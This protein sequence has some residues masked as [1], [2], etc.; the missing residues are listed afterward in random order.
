[1]SR[2]E[3]FF[4]RAW[5]WPE[6]DRRRFLQ[7]MAASLAL[8]GLVACTPV[9]RRKAVPYV[10][11]PPGVVEGGV[12][13]YATAFTLGGFAQGLLAKS[14][15]GRPIKL[16]GNP[17]HPSSRGRSDALAQ[18]AI[19]GLYDPD[20]SQSVLRQGQPSTWEAFA[21]ALKERLTQQQASGGR[22]LRILT[23]RVTSPSLE[24]LLRRLLRTYP[25]ARWISYEPIAWENLYSGTRLALGQP[26][27]PVYR[28]EA[29]RVILALEADFLHTFPGSVAYQQAFA[30]GRRPGEGMNRLYAVESGLSLTGA[31]ADH[32]LGLKPS[33]LEALARD[34]AHYLGLLPGPA[35][36]PEQANWIK[37]LAADLEAHRGASLVVA[38]PQTSPAVQAIAQALNLSLGNQGRTVT[39]LPPLEAR[40]GGSL[41]ELVQE[42]QAGQ[43]DTLLIL[44][45]NPVYTAPA[46]LE[47]AQ[48]LAQVPFSVHLGLYADETAAQ[49]TWHLPEAH[50]LEAWGDARAHDGTLSLIQPL[51]EPLYGGK[52]AAEVLSLALGNPQSSYE[53]LRSHYQ[54]LWGATGFEARWQKAV[55]DGLVAGSAPAPRQVALQPG[56]AQGLPAYQPQEGLELAFRPDPMLFDGRFANNAWLQEA[57]KPLTHLTWDNAL[58][59]GPQ[60]A[61]ALGLLGPIRQAEARFAPERPMV[62]LEV[63]GRRLELPLWVAPS[64]PEGCFTLYLGHGRTRAGQVGNKVGF[65]AY[66]LRTQA[67]PDY[68]AGVAVQP[69]GRRYPLASTQQHF[70]L[71]G[72]EIFHDEPLSA[73]QATAAKAKPTPSLYPEW[74]SEPHAWAMVIDTSLCT[75]CNACVLACQ[76]ENNIPVVGKEE[77]LR[78]REMHWIRIERY[79]HEDRVHHQPVPCQHCEKA[80]CEPVCPVAATVHS[81]EGLNLMVYNRCVGT[82][83][84]SNNCPYKVRRFNF[85]PYAEAF[86]GQGDPRAAQQSPLTLLMNPEVS[87]RSRGVMEKCTYCVQRIEEARIQASKEGRPIQP[88]EVQTACQQACPSGAIVFGDLKAPDSA[89]AALRQDPRHFTLLSEINTRPRTTY[90]GR[91]RNPNPALKER[92]DAS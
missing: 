21:Q 4:W 78:G 47:F 87:V 8:G 35:L 52:S 73:Y 10:K 90:L 19:L 68:V 29:A 89:V 43:V 31:V 80:P 58:I 5:G 54:A 85:F 53:L 67:H 22:G 69:T 17:E 64:H 60:T 84:C 39:Y 59:C 70:N 40:P 30:Q 25:Q 28:L 37:A 45:A 42:M 13:Y 72:L 34:L 79:H 6:F 75:G 81:G 36:L 62:A 65:D 20:R 7:L 41:A 18:A 57:P 48:A 74:P 33:Q 38:G 88:S 32:R 83:Y 55:H 11:Q 49:T 14:Y 16:E 76:A 71:E 92:G 82:K 44:S 12:T 61:E 50:F 63:G 77:V 66:R 9:S 1:M 27:W 15:H 86:I 24:A 46:D 23:E 3:E 56:W 51:I 2:D 26:L 91:V